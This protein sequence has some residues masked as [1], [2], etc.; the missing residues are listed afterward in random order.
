MFLQSFKN[1]LVNHFNDIFLLLILICLIYFLIKPLI[2]KWIEQKCLT[3]L[4]YLFSSLIVCITVILYTYR[5]YQDLTV[6]H[7]NQLFISLWIAIICIGLL[8]MVRYI[9]KSPSHYLKK[10]KTI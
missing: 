4:T 7:F 8:L 6:V 2:K 10:N 5:A 9:V 1:N 3:T